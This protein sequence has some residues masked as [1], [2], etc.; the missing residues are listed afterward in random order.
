MQKLS[1][2]DSHFTHS[3]MNFGPQLM[4]TPLKVMQGVFSDRLSG[5]GIHVEPSLAESHRVLKSGGVHGIFSSYI[6]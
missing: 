6:T 1:F 4:Q 3:L 2:P 5:S